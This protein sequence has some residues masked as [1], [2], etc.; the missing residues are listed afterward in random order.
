ESLDGI[1]LLEFH[2][3][4]AAFHTRSAADQFSLRDERGVFRR[5]QRRLIFVVRDPCPDERARTLVDV[6]RADAHAV[7][8]LN[9]VLVQPCTL[10]VTRLGY[11]HEVTAGAGQT[12]PDNLR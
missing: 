3:R 7:A 11:D 10:A 5:E 2:D 12:E 4:C 1:S 9:R 8:A 6:G